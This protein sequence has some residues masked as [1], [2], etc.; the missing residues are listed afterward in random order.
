MLP[1]GPTPVYL[2]TFAF[3]PRVAFLLQ[4]GDAFY[5]P[6][7]SDRQAAL[8]L[9]AAFR[10]RLPQAIFEI[11][12][13]GEL[14]AWLKVARDAGAGEVWTDTTVETTPRGPRVV[15]G[16]SIPSTRCWRRW[17]PRCSRRGR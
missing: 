1:I 10:F 14:L 15:P 12:N 3:Q 11:P 6:A 4:C 5:L 16:E 13:D 7:F 2:P 17:R 8:A 9:A